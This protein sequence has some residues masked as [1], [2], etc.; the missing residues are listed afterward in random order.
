VRDTGIRWFNN[1]ARKTE[2]PSMHTRNH[3]PAQ[4]V[5]HTIVIHHDSIGTREKALCTLGT[6]AF[7]C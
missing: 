4:L 5:Y 1:Q 6:F 3:F 7:C 2:A